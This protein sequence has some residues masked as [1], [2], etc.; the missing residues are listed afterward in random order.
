MG[1]LFTQ[2][3]RSLE[4]TPDE[5]L[6]L[7]AWDR[8]R[9]ILKSE[10]KRRGLWH[11]PPSY[12]GIHGWT[13]WSGDA[14]G[15]RPGEGALEDLVADCYSFI[16]VDRLGRLQAQL[17]AKPNIEGLI[18]LN[19]RHFFL[20][21]QKEHD[22]LGYRVFEM[23]HAAVLQALGEGELFVL[24]GDA[25]VRNPTVLGF[26]PG[27]PEPSMPASSSTASAFAPLVARWN[28][29]LLP[30]LVL[31]R[32]RRQ[33][34]VWARLRRLMRGL[35][36]QGIRSFRFRDIVDPLKRGARL[37]WAALL[38][39]AEEGG[40]REVGGGTCE[41]AGRRV[42]PENPVESRQSLEKLT[43]YISAA[44]ARMPMEP[45]TREYLATLWQFLKLQVGAGEPAG[46]VA[47]LE[48]E[49]AGAAED[50]DGERLSYR[51]LA[52]LLEI[53]RE[54]LPGLFSTLRQLALQA[55]HQSRRRARP[56][57]SL[58]TRPGRPS[59]EW[60]EVG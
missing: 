28:D 44:L 48:A 33:E 50:V 55:Q 41:G 20:E 56:A 3:V 18:L 25:Q 1:P 7:A 8:L 4:E 29:E 10:L 26:A 9:E 16:F 22:P 31:A 39:D 46:T 52:Q 45:R 17:R 14:A 40:A 60:E 36:P 53:P 51:R 12:L 38:E 43:R 5:R 57:P 32:G 54:R 11:S 49:I 58:E 2:F 47:R 42:L 30:D 59:P 13:S 34:D 37:R 23:V 19:V 24:S 21:R 15:H 27:A 6:A 35:E